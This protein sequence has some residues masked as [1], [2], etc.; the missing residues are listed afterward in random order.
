MYEGKETGLNRMQ[1]E[2]LTDH[3]TSLLLVSVVMG[4]NLTD[5]VTHK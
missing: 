1:Y 3:K 4:Y 5:V 2:H